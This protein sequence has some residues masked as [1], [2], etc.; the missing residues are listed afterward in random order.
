MPGWILPAARDRR[1]DP[2]WERLERARKRSGA[3]AAAFFV[4][5]DGAV[6]AEHYAGARAPRSGADSVQP[7]SRFNVYSVR[8]TYIG[9]AA[10]WSLAQ[11]ALERLDAALSA[12][13]P[14]PE[15]GAFAGVTIRHLLTHT[16]GL[17]DIR[18]RIVRRFA[19]GTAWHY[20]NA[21]ISL[22][23]EAI[24][25]ATGRTVADIVAAEIGRPLGLRESGWQAQ[26]GPS[27]VCDVD[28]GREAP[29]ILGEP[30]GAGRNLYVSARELALWGWLH[31]SGGEAAGLRVSEPRLF[32]MATSVQSP[33]DLPP[34][35]PRQGFCWWVRVPGPARS[36]IG[37][38]VPEGSCQILGMSGCQCLVI[39]SLRTVAVRMQNQTGG[40][41]LTFVRDARRFG[42]DVADALR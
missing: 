27:L 23:C 14:E 36:E 5:R 21:G 30:D 11:G 28:G 24:R 8:K 40:N 37:A 19:P 13:V 20:S 41:R 15:Q 18:G 31:A 12:Y 29:L 10:A 38:R 22:L 32:Q 34:R 25:R 1:F 2:V 4:V 33:A 6:A 3:T 26:D 16:H 39:P 35:L 42:D 7:S 17:D 9:F